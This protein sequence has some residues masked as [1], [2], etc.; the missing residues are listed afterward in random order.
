VSVIRILDVQALMFS[1]ETS[2]T[3][4]YTLGAK[5]RLWSCD[6]ALSSSYQNPESIY[7]IGFIKRP[8]RYLRGFVIFSLAPKIMVV[9]S[10]EF[11]GKLSARKEV[12]VEE[13]QHPVILFDSL[14]PH[15][16][17]IEISNTSLQKGKVPTLPITLIRP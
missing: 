2:I 6:R 17:G 1:S 14:S 7:N 4:T 3:K 11:P 5:L 12:L 15:F 13:A 9:G 16:K 8:S 10:W